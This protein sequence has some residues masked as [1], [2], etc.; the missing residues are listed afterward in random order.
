VREQQLE[1]RNRH[2]KKF[3][4]GKFNLETEAQSLQRNGEEIHL[5]IRPFQVLLFLIEN[6][7]RVVSRDELLDKFW[8]GHDVYDDALRKCVGVIRKA[9]DDTEKSPRFIETRRG[10]GYRFIGAVFE[11]EGEKEPGTWHLEI[12]T[13]Q[14]QRPKT[15]DQKISSEIRNPQS[16]IERFS[17]S[18]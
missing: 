15:E 6:H 4:F 5:A 12:G 7:E 18:F 17:L 3:A 13:N 10:S 8:D 14:D 2:N 11:E 9:L 1:N 16:A